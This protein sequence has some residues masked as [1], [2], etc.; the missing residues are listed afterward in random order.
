MWVTY[1]LSM[2]ILISAE[3]FLPRSNGVTNSVLRAAEYLT[4]NG[5]QVLIIA[6]GEGPQDVDGVEV[7][8]VP[9]LAL[10]T[11]AQIDI[12]G[13]S[14]N[15]IVKIIR[16][17]SPDIVHLASPF[18]LGEQVR[19]AAVICSVPVIANFQTDVSG[20]INFYGLTT[21]K[22]LIERRIRKI[23]NGSTITLAPSSDSENYLR[24]LGV[25]HI[26][27]WGR[28]VDLKQFN[29]SWRSNSVRRSWGADAETCVIGFVGR[30]APEKQV[31]KLAFLNDVGVLTGKKVKFVIVGDGPS[32]SALEKSFASALFLGHLSGD[33]LS[34]AMASMDFL[35][36]TGE[37]ET[38]C[39]VIQEAM[40]AGLPVVAPEIGG[41]RDLI[42][43][44]ITGLFYTPGDNFD[45][46]KRVLSLVNFDQKRDQMSLAAFNS[47]Q[48]RTW[49]SVCAELL[50]I[51]ENVLADQRRSGQAS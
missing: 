12:P 34:K 25:N 45:I 19:K 3:S 29:P 39:Q 28:G 18:L 24:S 35:V 13:I 11:F 4:R 14:R 42:N 32:R 50:G 17:F 30:L 2:R 40:A 9:A 46:R 7:R 15:S 51:Y 31:H 1:K 44:E 36:T 8:R 41:P 27:R 5:H 33:A 43:P 6:S 16:E 10:Q 47:V 22:S 26:V 20:F 23:H 21:A 49:D 48:S 37:N 38:F